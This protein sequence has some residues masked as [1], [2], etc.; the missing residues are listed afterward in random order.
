MER[1]M[2]FMA[3]RG[4]VALQT[5]VIVGVLLA[6][7]VAVEEFE[8]EF[9]EVSSLLTALVSGGIFTVA[10]VVAGT[11]TDFKESERVPAEIVAGLSS[12]HTDAVMFKKEKPEFDLGRL[13]ARLRNVVTSFRTDLENGERSCVKSINALSESFAEMD[14][15]EVIATYISRLRGEQSAIRKSV[16]RVYHIQQTEFVPSAYMLIWTILFVA[17]G[18]L[19]FTENDSSTEAYVL[20]GAIY[21]LFI[22]LA[23][24]LR[25]LD[26][27]FQPRRFTH[28]DV[29][30]FLLD[31]FV[32]SLDTPPTAAASNNE[33]PLHWDA[34]QFASDVAAELA[35]LTEQD[36]TTN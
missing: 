34:R 8:W 2:S 19:T 33:G 23:R 1:F 3:R 5:L 30:L 14:R 36:Q 26:T 17:I 6:L 31:D 18:M 4:K 24:L 21:F 9:V 12:I 29:D 32:S 20:L 7:R 28:D 11:L 35:R 22:Y 27:P 25:I 16:L 13:E 10:L 15:L